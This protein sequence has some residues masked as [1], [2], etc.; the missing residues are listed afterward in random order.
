[1]QRD[2]PQLN[3][4]DREQGQM[5]RSQMPR[6]KALAALWPT[7]FSKFDKLAVRITNDQRA[8]AAV[9]DGSGASNENVPATHIRDKAGKLDPNGPLIGSLRMSAWCL[10]K[11]GLATSGRDHRPRCSLRRP[12]AGMKM[13]CASDVAALLPAGRGQAASEQEDLC[14]PAWT[15]DVIET[16]RNSREFAKAELVLE[17]TEVAL[18]VLTEC[19]AFLI[20]LLRRRRNLDETPAAL[21][22]AAGLLQRP[23]SSR[24]PRQ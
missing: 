23:R 14:Q 3:P 18:D 10:N 19:R 20:K 16:F 21:S 17:D 22:E 12:T 9:L 24:R 2:L 7:L 6:A 4:L 1:M 8:I 13:Q 11:K 15:G 5:R